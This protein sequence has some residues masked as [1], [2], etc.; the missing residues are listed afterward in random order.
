MIHSSTTSMRSQKILLSLDEMLP[1]SNPPWI[2]DQ[3]MVK[4]NF[5]ELMVVLGCLLTRIGR[6]FKMFSKIILRILF[7]LI[8]SWKTRLYYN[9]FM[10]NKTLLN[11][12]CGNSLMILNLKVEG[13]WRLDGEFYLLIE[14]WAR[15]QSSKFC[16]RLWWMNLH[17]ELANSQLGSSLVKVVWPLLWWSWEFLLTLF[18][19]EIA[20]MPV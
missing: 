13:K 7:Q 20:L 5:S 8:P 15:E 10:E 4:M 6:R 3:D 18:I 2:K 11:F 12:K 14:K 16:W 17:Q 1:F 19:Y 9:P